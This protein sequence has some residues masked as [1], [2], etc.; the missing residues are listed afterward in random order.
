MSF[1]GCCLDSGAS[2]AYGPLMLTVEIP[3]F[4][5]R[6]R[7]QRNDDSPPAGRAPRRLAAA[8]LIVASLIGATFTPQLAAAAETTVTIGHNDATTVRGTLDKT[9]YSGA[10]S[11]TS[12]NHYATTGAFLEIVF[13]GST[14]K[15]LGDTRL[16]HGTGTVF[17]DDAAAGSVAYG[18][19]TNQTTRVLYTKDGLAEGRHTLRLE[20]NGFIDHG[21]AVVTS[22][23][24]EAPAPAGDL[25]AA[26]R[27]ASARVQA[28]YTAASWP[29]FAA[30]RD[31]ATE[32]LE[33]EPTQAEYYAAQAALT[34]AVD[35]L[36]E[37]RGLQ[38]LIADYLTRVPAEHTAESWTPFADALATAQAVVATADATKAAA[39]SAKN[40]LQDTAASL[41]TVSQGSF[42][43]IANN[44]FWKDTDGNSIYS[45]GG[46]IF[47]FGD[48]YYWYGVHYQEAEPYR[49][50]PSRTYGTSTFASIPVYSS[51]DL[52]NWT[53]EN[54]VATRATPLTAP[55]SKGGS[56]SKMTSM[57]DL[58]WVGRLGVAYNE[59][60]GKYTL[61]VQMS[62]RIDSGT[63]PGQAVLLLQGDSP[64]DDFDYATLQQ[65]ITNSPTTGTGDQTVFTDEDGSDY[66]VFSNRAGRSRA[67]VSKISDSDSLTIEP[68]TQIGYSAE[69]REGNAMFRL[70]ETYY[71]A[72]SD[73]HGWNTSVNYVRESLTDRIQGAYSEEYVLPGTER[74]YSHVTQ[75]G[76]FVTVHGTK[77]DTVLYAG[78]RW[79]D[80]AW[81]GIGYNQWMPLSASEDG[82]S[83]NSLSAWEFNATTGEWRVGHGN[84]YV[85]NPD[86]QAD[87][88]AVSTV[89]GWTTTVDTEYSANAF[90]SNSSPGANS[91]RFALRLGDENAFSGSVQ[92]SATVPDGVYRF[93]AKLNTAGGLEYA[94][95]VITG[96]TGQRYELDLNQAGAGWRD[97]ELGGMVITGGTATVSI[98]ARSAGGGQSVRVDALS[99]V[100][101]SE[102]VAP[103][104]PTAPGIGVSDANVNVTWTAPAAGTSPITGYTV[105]LRPLSGPPLEQ[106]VAAGATKATFAAPAAGVYRASVV[107]TSALGASPS[108]AA[109]AAATV[110]NSKPV[111]VTV[112]AKSQCINGKATVAVHA[113]NRA[114]SKA[115][116]RLKALGQEKAFSGVASSAAA[117]HLFGT[118]TTSVPAGQAGVAAYTWSN[119]V[120]YYATYT[121]PYP[122]ISC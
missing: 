65:Q 42:Q 34:T 22:V 68:A 117:H 47:R 11:T 112:S 115:D 96:A 97:V 2:R 16:G 76:F 35:G 1:V 87:R 44:T 4:L 95:A 91:S 26:L 54:D 20:A 28:D 93:A 14:V 74:D 89:T 50:S 36:V 59:N 18:G 82:V 37:I 81:N 109:S 31:S 61:L 52:V 30:A 40:A 84:N 43:P 105:T 118:G 56:F 102:G 119:G 85:L 107:A 92:Q 100:K 66:L 88:V 39:V 86:F 23:T 12:R 38:D 9:F 116:L 8:V 79:A 122:A 49:N 48:T 99:L 3:S 108:S 46:G 27:S 33:G 62:N 29:A 45:Q 121:A 90:V 5:S 120:G 10:W 72:A 21:G 63:V 55:P 19:S 78:D 73:L 6:L 70:G 17:I 103:T 13:E 71:M 111:P 83:F 113:L 101:E 7:P 57:D 110:T 106:D 32:L 94:R 104:T 80:F 58:S 69:G 41:E 51:K 25:E 15:L 64:T 24:P 77:Q 53:F 67:F 114:S 98:E 60:T 75:T